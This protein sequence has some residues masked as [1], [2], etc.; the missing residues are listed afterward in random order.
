MNNFQKAFAYVGEKIEGLAFSANV[1]LTKQSDNKTSQVE[2]EVFYGKINGQNSDG[3]KAT[4]TSGGGSSGGPSVL[5]L[6]QEV[7]QAIMET[8]IRETF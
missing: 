1:F 3:Q 4:G 5:K 6:A 2:K 8:P 7:M